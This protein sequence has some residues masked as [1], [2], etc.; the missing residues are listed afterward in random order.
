MSL[1]SINPFTDKVIK[2]FREDGSKTVP[3]KIDDAYVAYNEWRKLVVPVRAKMLDDAGENLA[4]YKQDYAKMITEEMGKPIT[5][6]VAEIVKCSQ[7]LKYY[8]LHAKFMLKDKPVSTGAENSYVCF[9]PLGV[10]LGIMPW[11]YPFW[12]VL[13]F[14]VPALVSGNTV[15]VKH[16][17]NVQIC[18][19]AIQQMFEDSGF[20]EH[21]Y[22]NLQI[23]SSS[24]AKV[25]SNDKIAAVS[26]TGSEYAGSKV[27]RL[28]G[29]KLKKSVLELGGSDPFVV[30]RDANLKKAAEIAVKARMQNNGQS[31]IAAKRIIVEEIVYD[32]FIKLLKAEIEKLHIGDPMHKDTDIGPLAKEE[33]VKSIHDKVRYS[34][35]K[36]AKVELGGIKSK[37]KGYFYKPTLLT[38]V[39]P[40]M[41]VFD[42]E[43]FGPVL[44]VTIAKDETEAI[45]LANHPKYGLGASVWTENMDQAE[46]LV[47]QLEA[48]MVV[49]NGMVASN[50]LMPFGGIK[51]SGYGRELAQYGVREFVNIK[52]VTFN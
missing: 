12:Q 42:D 37:R 27:A 10:I 49:V 24:V 30:F 46:R 21:V 23:G 8:A 35:K 2:S 17:S 20:P 22:Q 32:S 45:A 18:A 33:F 50:P 5:Q 14:A 4:R 28:A 15:L 7:L 51:K 11:N 48:G 39:R 52:S 3:R 6:S 26:I 1:K 13:R 41:P 29:E 31:C 19:D 43:V 16:A 34:V 25:I 9:E 38:N 47:R 36:G 44:P 40:G